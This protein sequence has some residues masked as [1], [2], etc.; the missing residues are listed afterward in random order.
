MSEN[1]VNRF[2]TSKEICEALGLNPSKIHSLK[3]ILDGEMPRVEVVMPLFSSQSGILSKALANYMLVPD[4]QRQ[5][6]ERKLHDC[7]IVD[8]LE[9]GGKAS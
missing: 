7:D 4:L 3:I 5:E 8:P 6:I 2:K 1:I 9:T